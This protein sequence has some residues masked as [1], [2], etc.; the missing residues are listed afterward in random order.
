MQSIE[1]N[2]YGT[3]QESVFG[4]LIFNIFLS[5]LF[6]FLYRA[7][8]TSHT[9]DTTAYSAKETKVLVIKEIERFSKFFFSGLT[10]IAWKSI[11]VKVVYYTQEMTLK[12]LISAEMAAR[13]KK[14]VRY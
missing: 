12:V 13:L 7:T 4:P 10:L 6:C 5:G 9:D 3:P 1:R 11:V 8:T 14:R 2:F